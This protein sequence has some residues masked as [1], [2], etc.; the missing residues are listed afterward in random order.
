MDCFDHE[1]LAVYRTAIEFVA[2]VGELL[3]SLLADCRKSA[4]ASQEV[5]AFT[6]EPGVPR[7]A[8]P[9][10][11]LDARLGSAAVAPR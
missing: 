4:V 11:P 7:A 2:W 5:R 3:D 8:C 9:P 1:K 6:L 10:V